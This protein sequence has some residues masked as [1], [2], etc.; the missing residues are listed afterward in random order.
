MRRAALPV[1][2]VALDKIIDLL[3]AQVHPA[4]FQNGAKLG[5]G[6]APVAVLVSV[7]KD[8]AQGRLVFE[9]FAELENS[10]LNSIALAVVVVVG[11]G[12]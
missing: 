1:A 4:A 9:D 11:G 2:V 7:K 12:E 5:R 3:R 6:H 10:M 8:L